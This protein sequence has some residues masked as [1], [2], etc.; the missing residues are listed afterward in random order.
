MASK[1]EQVYFRQ[2]VQVGPLVNN[3]YAW[4]HMIPPVTYSLNIVKRYQRIL[5]SYIHSPK[6]HAAA[7]KNPAMRG[8]PFMDLDVCY[9]DKAKQLLADTLAST[10]SAKA[11]V[12][13]IETT[14]RIVKEKAIGF[15]MNPLYEE[16]P[17]DFRG[18]VELFYDLNHIPSFRVFESMLYRSNFYTTANQSISLSV[19]KNDVDRPF[20]LSTPRF[21]NDE[22]LIL[23]IPFH[24]RG[25]DELFRMKYEPK[26]IQFIKKEL[27]LD[28]DEESSTLF[29]SFFTIKPPTPYQAYKGENFRM[30]YFGHACILIETGHVN[31]LVDPVL[32]YTYE[33]DISRLTYEDLPPHIDYILITHA[34]QDHILIETLLQLRHKV[35]QIIVGRNADGH[36]QDPS[37]KLFLQSIGF[38][39]IIELRDLETVSF[40]NG[41]ITAIPFLGE[42]HDIGIQSKNCYHIRVD[43]STLMF[44]ADSCNIEPYLYEHIHQLI[45]DVDILFLGMECDGAPASW[46]YGPLFLEPLENKKSNDR[47]GRGSN[48]IEGIEIVKRFNCQEVFVYAMGLEPWLK[49][50]L[51]LEYHEDSTPIIESN[52]LLEHCEGIGIK[53]QRLYG[54]QEIIVEKYAR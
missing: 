22:N 21:K 17:R 12:E 30:R 40:Q 36:L 43:Q 27:G 51:G 52:R 25:L 37:L 3:W 47:R 42:H 32:S 9:M 15:S 2:D 33:S 23:R 7:V 16:L 14:N 35:K 31:I 49:Y 50:I 5:D 6:I 10:K 53:S 54:E 4:L 19:I 8:G 20:I 28:L 38:E 11:L 41:E 29:H 46:V 26:S 39:N 45:G 34:H 1:S 13:A 48:Y 44:M 24:H 18:Y